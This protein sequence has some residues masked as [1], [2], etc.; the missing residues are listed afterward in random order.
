MVDDGETR[1]EATIREAMEEAF[2][3]PNKDETEKAYQWLKR[4]VP[5]G[6]TVS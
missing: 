4:N 6:K 5:K 2:N 1:E 3:L